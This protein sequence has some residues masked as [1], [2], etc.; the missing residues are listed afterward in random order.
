MLMAATVPLASLRQ[1]IS[2]IL[3]T[4][5][6]LAHLGRAQ[7]SVELPSCMVGKQLGIHMEASFTRHVKWSAVAL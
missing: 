4:A 5:M 3:L 7:V 1:A 6:G 2:L